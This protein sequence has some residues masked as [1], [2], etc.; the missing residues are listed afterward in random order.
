MRLDLT[1]SDFG[2]DVLLQEVTAICGVLVTKDGGFSLG[3]QALGTEVT[4]GRT[5]NRTISIGDLTN[6]MIVALI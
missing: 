2:K 4:V 1:E 5:S 3:G 6:L